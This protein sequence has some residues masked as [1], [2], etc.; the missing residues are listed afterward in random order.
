MRLWLPL[1]PPF[2]I[3]SSSLRTRGWMS[4]KKRGRG[5]E[6][7]DEG[8]ER[9]GEK[10]RERRVWK[11]GR[12]RGG[13]K[14]RMREGE[15]IKQMKAVHVRHKM[16]I[17]TDTRRMTIYFPKK[18]TFHNISYKNCVSRRSKSRKMNLYKDKFDAVRRNPYSIISYIC[19]YLV[20][21]CYW[22]RLS[23]V[24][25]SVP[26]MLQTTCYNT[27]PFEVRI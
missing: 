17:M 12:R 27:N 8:R 23:F 6:W 1:Q 15:V 7:G 11:R 2:L 14:E 10:G 18:D 13:D 9:E 22:L 4:V 24:L 5:R 26:Q 25:A 21:G 20:G 3:R 19:M 16:V